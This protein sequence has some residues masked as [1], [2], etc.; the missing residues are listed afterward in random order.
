MAYSHRDVEAAEVGDD[1]DSEH[2]DA[3][4]VGY[5]YFWNGAHT[6]SVTAQTFVHTILS[7]SLEG[8]PL[9][10]H[11]HAMYNLYVFLL[12]N[13]L[14]QCDHAMV[15]SLV[16]IWESRSGREVLSSQRMLWEHVDMIGDNHQVANLEVLIHTA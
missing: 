7:R 3:T 11:I 15:V 6:H 9:Y 12:C 14:C 4:V 10:T 13:L 1:A 5:N 2:L 8:W 16:H